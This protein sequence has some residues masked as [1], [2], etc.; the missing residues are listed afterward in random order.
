MTPRSI[1]KPLITA[2]LLAGMASTAV[3]ADMIDAAKPDSVTAFFFNK[4]IASKQITDSY[5][6][7]LV[8]LRQDDR[9]Y[10]V[11]FYGCT[12]GAAC[13]SLQLY[14]GYE[15]DGKVG[16]DVVNDLNLEI[17]YVKAAIDKE[18][19][20]VMMLDIFTGSNGVPAD[21]FEMLF[22]LFTETVAEFEDTVGWVSD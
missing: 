15:T 17:R 1:A 22:G 5:G 19:D 3:A 4:G 12:D 9:E 7:P 10:L 13:N 14:R 20:V 8:Q 11:F 2:A 18:D 6:D 16:Q 21:E